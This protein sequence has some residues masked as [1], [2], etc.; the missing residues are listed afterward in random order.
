MCCSDSHHAVPGSCDKMLF[1]LDCH[2]IATFYSY[3]VIFFPPVHKYLGIVVITLISNFIPLPFT[4]M[5]EW[6]EFLRRTASQLGT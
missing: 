6:N 1:T 4:N 5:N 3:W 2:T